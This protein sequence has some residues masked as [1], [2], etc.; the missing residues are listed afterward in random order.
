MEIN[1]RPKPDMQRERESTL[2]GMCPSNSIP[3]SSGNPLKRGDRKGRRKWVTS[4]EGQQKSPLNQSSKA[5]ITQSL[6]PS[7]GPPCIRSSVYA[8]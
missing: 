1:T 2:S 6:N 5:H 7:T 4:D 8:V 3:Q